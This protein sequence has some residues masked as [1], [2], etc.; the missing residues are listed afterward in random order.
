[1]NKKCVRSQKQFTFKMWLQQL[2]SVPRS[3]FHQLRTRNQDAISLVQHNHWK[4]GDTAILPLSR[5]HSQRCRTLLSSGS[6]DVII[7]FVFVD[8]VYLVAGR[9][10]LSACAAKDVSLCLLCAWEGILGHAVY[11]LQLMK[12]TCFPRRLVNV[13]FFSDCTVYLL[14]SLCVYVFVSMYVFLQVWS[15]FQTVFS[16]EYR[17]TTYMMMAVWFS[18]SFR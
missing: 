13:C 7:L 5:A 4:N 12:E 17:R 9:V 11:F 1:M 14:C 15:N 3:S 10:Y 6:T 16:P 8:D 2:R 18:M